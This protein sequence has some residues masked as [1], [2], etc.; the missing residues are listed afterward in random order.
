MSRGRIIA[1]VMMA[2]VVLVVG[3]GGV[4]K[5]SAVRDTRQDPY[6]H[7][8]TPVAWSWPGR[9][10]RRRRRRGIRVMESGCALWWICAHVLAVAALV[11]NTLRAEEWFLGSSC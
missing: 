1:Q 11:G 4:A 2:N 6:D 3:R 10:R 9:R 8:Q 5:S 7:I